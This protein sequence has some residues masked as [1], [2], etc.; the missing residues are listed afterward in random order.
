MFARMFLLMLNPSSGKLL[1][2][3]A[4]ALALSAS[5]TARAE[6]APA[7][8]TVWAERGPEFPPAPEGWQEQVPQALHPAL[9][10]SESET[11]F[12]LVVFSRDYADAVRPRDVPRRHERVSELRCF[13][14]RGEYEPVTFAVH[15]LRDVTSL[16]VQAGELRNDEAI[17]PAGQI[18][19]RWVRHVRQVTDKKG[20]LYRLIPFL[21]ERQTQLSVRAGHNAQVW[22]TLKVPAQATPGIYKGTISLKADGRDRTLSLR[23]RVLPFSLPE[24]AA[25]MVMSDRRPKDDDAFKRN[26][27][28][29]REHG[30]QGG[31]QLASVEV[32]SRDRKFGPDDVKATV[33]NAETATRIYGEVFGRMPER[34]RF[35]IGHQILY[36]WNHQKFWFS[37][38]PCEKGEKDLEEP[39][40]EAERLVQEQGQKMKGDFVRAG[41]LMAGLAK[42]NGWGE[43]WAYVIDEPG[44]HGH[45]ADAIY[46][47]NYLKKAVPGMKTHVCIGG[48]I[49]MGMDEI[50]QLTPAIDFF[51]LNRFS[52]AVYETLVRNG[53]EDSYGVYNGGSSAEKIGEFVR[54][55]FF[56]GFYG[57]RSG[58]REILQWVYQ[59][60]KPFQAP[61]RGNHGYSYATPEGPLPSIAFECLR[62][63]IDDYRYAQLLHGM[64]EKVRKSSDK[65]A[66]AAVQHAEEELSWVMQNVGLSYQAVYSR[67]PP[68]PPGE[69]H[70]WRWLVA[71]QILSLADHLA[72]ESAP[73]TAPPPPTS[74]KEPEGRG[75]DLILGEELV[76][77][78][79]FEGIADKAWGPWMVQVWG[80]KGE[81]ALD[82]TR[83]HSGKQCVRIT[84]TAP[85]GPEKPAISVL[86]WA[87]W[88][89]PGGRPSI[90]KI[91][92]AGHTYILSAWV[93]GKSGFL[94]TLRIA[95]K[96]GKVKS[97]TVL[98]EKK[99]GWQELK[100]IAD[101]VK[102]AKA[103]YLCVWVM[104]AP[105]TVWVDDLSFREVKK[106]DLTLHMPRRLFTDDDHA[107]SLRLDT[108]GKA[109][110]IEVRITHESGAAPKSLRFPTTGRLT[111]GEGSGLRAET[112]VTGRE[113]TVHFDPSRLPVGEHTIRAQFVREG[114]RPLETTVRRI[115]GPLSPE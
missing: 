46:W 68:P 13:A 107:A 82:S 94:P 113:F 35:G 60:G 83:A 63:G 20:K 49:A 108:T 92:E 58:A 27:I 5:S 96:G 101:V 23:V 38:W 56:F 61:F 102:S 11:R 52:P 100:L 91:L 40:D 4:V 89:M 81:S 84:N 42:K 75:A 55:R 24:P 8:Y 99:D 29:L 70:R 97:R 48:G 32:V 71:S 74:W 111:A 1:V 22:L 28:D 50:G 12:G 115:A 47:N 3:C 105:A 62:E 34:F 88:R 43:P 37:F 98:G 106:S 44:G 104:G 109:G 72:P 103:S 85:G 54:D 26:L 79:D 76:P 18:D 57:F 69:I 53:R 93:K 87:S 25:E 17:I 33:K 110:E 80:G 112:T 19:L 64:I 114:S 36:Y 39:E 59:F 6:P 73:A 95:A 7:L 10:P 45:I 31:Q 86:V 15:A 65:A 67:K 9:A 2:R 14:A 77:K 16:S 51:H 41:K 21:L 78:G 30:L 66:Q 90:D